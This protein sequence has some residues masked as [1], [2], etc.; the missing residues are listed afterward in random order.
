VFVDRD[1]LAGE[2][3]AG[4]SLEQIGR[5]THRHASTVGYWAKKHGLVPPAAAR[6]ARRGAPDRSRLEALAEQGLSLRQ[7]ADELDRSIATVRH[8]LRAWNIERL[9]ARLRALPDDAPREIVRDCPKH[10]L[11]LHR[12][13]RRS[14]YRC[15]RC[16]ADAVSERR[17]KVKRILVAEA[18][19]RCVVCGYDRCIAALQFHHLDRASKQFA[20][21]NQGMTRSLDD[22]RTEARKCVL[23]CA[24]CHAEIEAGVEAP[25]GGFEPPRTD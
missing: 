13:D 16:S 7:I 5:E 17:R 1:W 4:K 20:L 2:F 15:T 12:L 14:T 19:G 3:A 21:S 25:R 24:N 8:W 18:G 22:A 6:F 23:V 10:G 9:D 11:A